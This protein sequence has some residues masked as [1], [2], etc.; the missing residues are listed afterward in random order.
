MGR[1]GCQGAVLRILRFAVLATVSVTACATA[2]D[3]L[4]T[5]T[6]VQ[7]SQLERFVATPKFAADADYIG[8]RSRGG[9]ADP[10]AIINGIAQRLLARGSYTKGAFLDDAIASLRAF[11][12]ADT[13]DRERAYGQVERMMDI[14][15]I[16]SSDG[17]LDEAF[18]GA[19]LRE[20][21]KP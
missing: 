3:H 7:R 17:R 19:D 4:A 8:F 5:L 21:P 20:H 9:V 13:E 12:A 6:R 2:P 10:D 14:L 18:Y 11:G 15:G 16:K 1:G